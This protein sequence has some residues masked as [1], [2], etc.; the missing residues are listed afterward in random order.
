[1][2]GS[3]ARAAILYWD[4]GTANIA[5]NGDSASAG[6]DG[7]WNSS[8]Q[9]WDQGAAPHVA[10]TNGNDAVLAGNAGYISLGAAISAASISLGNNNYVIATDS[11]SLTLTGGATTTGNY[12]QISGVSGLVVSGSQSFN[13]TGGLRVSAVVSGTGTLTKAG[14][15]MLSFSNSN[16]FSGKFVINEGRFGINGDAALGVVPAFPVADSIT[17]NGGTFANGIVS[18]AGGAFDNGGIF[19]L[20]PNRGVTLGSSGGTIQVGYGAGGRMSIA[21]VVSGDGRLTKT[22]GGELALYGANS[23]SGGTTISQGALS[24]GELVGGG[25]TN[26]GSN[27]GLGTGDV[28]V[29]AQGQLVLAGNNLTIPNNVTLNGAPNVNNRQGALVGG[30]QDG[31]SNNTLTG[32]LT[33]AGIGNHSLSTWWSDKTLTLAGPVTGPGTLGAVVSVGWA[34]PRASSPW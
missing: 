32:T 34:P 7:T 22:D 9:N 11:G 27:N 20:H 21:G 2:A 3:P 14:S 1:M 16:N 24:V 25:S 28:V 17:V 10:W 5:E 30:L 26:E 23:Y 29:E 13:I 6:G 19:T 8:I 15:G 12:H 4:G 18:N 33:L 31:G